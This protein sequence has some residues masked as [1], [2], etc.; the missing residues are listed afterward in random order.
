MRY[1]VIVPLLFWYAGEGNGMVTT[2]RP[3]CIMLFTI[4][5]FTMAPYFSSNAFL[6][7]V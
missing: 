6:W 7:Y 2:V 1:F 4:A 5:F 3:V